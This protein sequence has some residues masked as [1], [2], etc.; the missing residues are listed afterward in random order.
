MRYAPR[1]RHHGPVR[2][3]APHCAPRDLSQ[4]G[5]S[6]TLTV[7]AIFAIVYVGMIAGG[8]PFVQLDRT[9]IALLG[10]IALVAFGVLTPEQA[11][12]S[13]HV[14]TLLLLFSFMVI[15]AQMR[16]GGFYTWVTLRIAAIPVGAP[17]LLAA[18]IA[19]IAALSA[20]FSNDVICLAIAPVLADACLRRGLDPVPF[21]LALACAAN[22]G[23]A[24]TLIGNPQNMLRGGVEAFF[25]RLLP[26]GGDSGSHRP[27]ARLG[28]HR[29]ADARPVRG[30]CS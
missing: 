1:A 29:L 9:G 30:C 19:T 20:V 21:L 22:V 15:S 2:H 14:P 7:V 4:G 5:T 8:L 12:Q 23:S 26:R 27:G 28:G 11:A 17:T 3:H 16:L 25:R 24:A 6:V 13:V 18:A 10:A